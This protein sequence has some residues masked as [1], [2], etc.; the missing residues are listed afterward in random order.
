MVVNS[1]PFHESDSVISENWNF[2]KIKSKQS[3]FSSEKI[4]G[5]LAAYRL[6]PKL[7]RLQNL[8]VTF[9]LFNLKATFFPSFTHCL[10]S[11]SAV[12]ESILQMTDSFPA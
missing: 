8:R 5:N 2:W 1:Q 10:S 7:N 3:E 12:N 11:A 6:Q 4:Y 9:M